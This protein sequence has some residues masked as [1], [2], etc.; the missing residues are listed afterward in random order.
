VAL[1]VVLM[2]PDRV[3][4]P[5]PNA[6]IKGWPLSPDEAPSVDVKP[7][8]ADAQAALVARRWS[9]AQTRF[10]R[11]LQVQS[12]DPRASAGLETA[13]AE[14]RSA[15]AFATS[16]AHL[17]NRRWDEALSV[18]GGIPENSVYFEEVAGV[19]EEARK[20]IGADKVSAAR[21]SIEAGDLDSARRRLAELIASKHTREADRLQALIEKA[22]AVA[23]PPKK[24]NGGR[25]PPSVPTSL[26]E[27]VYLGSHLFKVNEV[28]GARG[29][30]KITADKNGGLRI[31][32]SVKASASNFAT[33]QGRLKIISAKKFTVT[34][35]LVGRPSFQNNRRFSEMKGTFGFEVRK[36]RRFWRLYTVN[37]KQCPCNGPCNVNPF[38]YVDVYRAK[39]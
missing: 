28:D 15:K 19:R 9:E 8:L 13:R 23:A 11:I 16:R 29:R 17:V 26:R 34:G 35:T 32:A 39:R 24:T 18:I 30:A 31:A 33:L 22:V 36:G 20:G 21:K 1:A 4:A 37:G 6:P 14:L 38:C 12:D 27:R 2:S 25:E 5:D 10:E 7:M 3:A